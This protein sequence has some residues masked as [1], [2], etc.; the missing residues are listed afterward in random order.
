MGIKIVAGD[1]TNG[2]YELC[3]SCFDN[4]LRIRD[5]SIPFSGSFGNKKGTLSIREDFDHIEIINEESKKKFIGT[6]AWGA[7]GA[8]VFGPLGLLAG[9]LA[10]G[11][12]KEVAFAAF[13]KDGRKFMAI[14]DSKT[15]N[16][17]LAELF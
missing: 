17:I 15:V 7:L 4:N 6:A 14:S 9:V 1:L 13:L 2:K 12:K 10:G 3:S 8:A 11:N 16:K 5:L